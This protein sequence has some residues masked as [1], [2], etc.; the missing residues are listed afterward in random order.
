MADG[1]H[2]T[3]LMQQDLNTDVGVEV[4]CKT[5]GSR[6]SSRLK[7]LKQRP[8]FE[9]C[10]REH[11]KNPAEQSADVGWLQSADEELGLTLRPDR[12]NTTRLI[13]GRGFQVETREL[14][15][16]C[17]FLEFHSPFYFL[18]TIPLGF[19]CN[20]INYLV[21][22]ISVETKTSWVNSNSKRMQMWPYASCLL[23]ISLFTGQPV[24]LYQSCFNRL[25]CC[26]QVAINC[27]KVIICCALPKPECKTS[28]AKEE[29]IEACI[30][31]FPPVYW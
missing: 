18:S 27:T 5:A 17:H 13:S 10:W 21:T 8:L 22:R 9:V 12:T 2:Q 20:I 29:N 23:V 15:S 4:G 3:Y 26:T 25:L 31:V 30:F 11:G 6:K 19:T 24:Q 7:Q 1:P 14:S 28:Q 16:N